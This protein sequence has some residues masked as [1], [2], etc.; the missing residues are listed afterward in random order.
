MKLLQQAALSALFLVAGCHAQQ[1]A[2]VEGTPVAPEVRKRVLAELR[3]NF[4]VPSDVEIGIGKEEPG[5]FAGYNK[6]PVTFSRAGRVTTVPF[7]ISS[8]QKTLARMEKYDLSK[9]L[10]AE[11]VAKKIDS[12]DRPFRGNPN[13]KVTVINFDDFQCPFCARMHEE[14]FPGIFDQYKDKV[15]FVYK[16]YPLVSIHPWAM[17][18]AVDANCLFAQKGTSAGNDAYWDFADRVHNTAKDIG[19]SHDVKQSEAELDKITREIAGKHNLD[20]GQL[21]ACM[22]KDDKAAVEKSMAEGDAVGV[23]STPTLFINGEKIEGAEPPDKIQQAIDNA[24]KQ[25]AEPEKP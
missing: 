10:L 24:L 9:V 4:T 14:L 23:N 22:A 19:A 16:D 12:A 1:K 5:E 7:M 21:S 25:A 8:D 17:H 2:A 20:A 18:A 6:L 3:Q 13:A 11:D 15:K